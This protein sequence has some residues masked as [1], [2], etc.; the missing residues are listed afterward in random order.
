VV[1]AEVD[2]E[3]ISGSFD[4]FMHRIVRAPF[5]YNGDVDEEDE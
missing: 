4:E 5:F 2:L 3:V 1:S